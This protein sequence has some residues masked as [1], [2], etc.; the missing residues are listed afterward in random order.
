MVN[1]AYRV[2]T[3]VVMQWV[4]LNCSR[5]EREFKEAFFQK[6]FFPSLHPGPIS[7]ASDNDSDEEE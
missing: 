6:K 3:K 2:T 7:N 1:T 5:I 4:A